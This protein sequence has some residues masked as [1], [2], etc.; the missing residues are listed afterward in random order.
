MMADSNLQDSLALNTNNDLRECAKEFLKITETGKKILGIIQ[1]QT[2]VADEKQMGFCLRRRSLSDL[3]RVPGQKRSDFKEKASAYYNVSQKVMFNL[4]VLSKLVV[5]PK[6]EKPRL[7]EIDQTLENLQQIL[8]NP[9]VRN[10]NQRAFKCI[11]KY[12]AYSGLLEQKYSD[13]A[14][15]APDFLG[16]LI[17]QIKQIIKLIRDRNETGKIPSKISE[18]YSEEASGQLFFNEPS[19]EEYFGEESY[20][21]SLAKL[22]GEGDSK[23]LFFFSD[24]K[25][26]HDKPLSSSQTILESTFNE[27]GDFESQAKKDFRRNGSLVRVRSSLD[28]PAAGDLDEEKS[29]NKFLE[30]HYD[31]AK[32][33]NDLEEGTDIIPAELNTSIS[34][35]EF[36]AFL[37][38]STQMSQAEMF[39]TLKE[40]YGIGDYMDAKVVVKGGNILNVEH[41][42]DKISLYQNNRNEWKMARLR[43]YY[44]V[45]AEKQINEEVSE[46]K[47]LLLIIDAYEIFNITNAQKPIKLRWREI[48]LL[49]QILP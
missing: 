11:K 2:L 39:N 18:A 48:I 28:L 32:L 7:S 12:E 27:A 10:L 1:S 9:S 21:T 25:K 26:P 37:K 36:K 6:V 44:V 4:H 17:R 22:S 3:V 29:E 43:R 34:K 38:L 42:S 40:H 14:S 31:L 35:E 13:S 46:D 47:A 30:H 45:D 16:P 41:P 24:V 49:P 5:N 20:F 23:I 33:M 8:Q 15:P 19:L